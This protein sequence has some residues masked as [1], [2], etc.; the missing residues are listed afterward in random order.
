MVQQVMIERRDEVEIGDTLGRDQFE[1][2]RNVETRQTDEGAA[3]QRHGQQRTHAH[4]MVERHGTKRA[5]VRRVEI[6]RDVGKRGG[7]LRALA[8]RHALGACG[9]AGG[10]KHHQPGLGVDPRPNRG[11]TAA[12]QR[13]ERQILRAR[14]ADRDARARARSI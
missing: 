7:A 6:L 2:A 8:A 10:V 13:I 1:R 5:L 3:D 11:R 12:D 4:R 9:R 14:L